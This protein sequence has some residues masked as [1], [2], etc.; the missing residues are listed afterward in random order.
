MHPGIG[1]CCWM[2]VCL[3]FSMKTLFAY[4]ALRFSNVHNMPHGVTVALQPPLH[5]QSKALLLY[6]GS[7]YHLLAHPHPHSE[8]FNRMSIRG[9]CQK[10]KQIYF[11][12]IRGNHQQLSSVEVGNKGSQNTQETAT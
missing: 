3:L 8:L 12:N 11:R 2:K 9:V 6:F 7:P 10:A 4:Q 5:S 1:P